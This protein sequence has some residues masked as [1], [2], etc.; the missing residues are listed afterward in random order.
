M[1][2]RSWCVLQLSSE[3]SLVRV[4]LRLGYAIYPSATSAATRMPHVDT[5]MPRG[6]Y[7]VTCDNTLLLRGCHVALTVDLLT[8]T[9]TCQVRGTRWQIIV[10]M[11][12]QVAGWLANEEATRIRGIR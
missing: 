7:M 12:W 2:Q 3:R 9:M 10:G 1:L 4:R 8:S 6:C 11:R 5:W